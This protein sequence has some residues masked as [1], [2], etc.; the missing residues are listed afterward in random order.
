MRSGRNC[1]KGS[2]KLWDQGEDVDLI[3]MGKGGLPG[4]EIVQGVVT[5]KAGMCFRISDW[6]GETH[7]AHK[8]CDK[9]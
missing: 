5:S 9:Y 6:D 1:L 4:I 3:G 2:L 8:D 7:A